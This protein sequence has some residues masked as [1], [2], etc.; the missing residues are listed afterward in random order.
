VLTTEHELSG[1]VSVLEGEVMF[2]HGMNTG[3]KEDQWQAVSQQR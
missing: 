3:A 1:E 2:L